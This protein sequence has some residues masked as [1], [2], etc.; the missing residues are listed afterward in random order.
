MRIE[1]TLLSAMTKIVD[2][3]KAE[4][5]GIYVSSTAIRSVASE[6][7][8][9][10]E[11]LGLNLQQVLLLIAITEHAS[12]SYIPELDIAEYLH[13]TMLQYYKFDPDIR[14]LE[15]KGY[16]KRSERAITVLES[17]L[18]ALKKNQAPELPAVEEPETTPSKTPSDHKIGFRVV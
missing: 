11:R 1:R 3:M 2:R 9:L 12:Y 13:I 7:L 6:I 10:E 16:I 17:G 4:K 14:V 8:Y 15:R 18:E 5:Y